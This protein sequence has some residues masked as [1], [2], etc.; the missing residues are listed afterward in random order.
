MPPGL[1]ELLEKMNTKLDSFNLHPSGIHTK[2]PDGEKKT[3]TRNDVTCYC[4]TH[5]S[6]LH[7]GADCK[8]KREGHKKEATFINKMGGSTYYCAATTD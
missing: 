8:R 5:G 7:K 4:W 3:Y 1:M 6:C 2:K